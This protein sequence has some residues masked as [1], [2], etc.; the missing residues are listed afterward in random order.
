M[1][2]FEIGKKNVRIKVLVLNMVSEMV[3]IVIRKSV[4]S[5]CVEG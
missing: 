2:F 5:F 1:K 3:K 4:I